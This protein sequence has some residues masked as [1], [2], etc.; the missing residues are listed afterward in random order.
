MGNPTDTGAVHHRSPQRARSW[1]PA[2][3]PPLLVPPAKP[4]FRYLS[5]VT[6]VQTVDTPHNAVLPTLLSRARPRSQLT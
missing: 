1:T 2:V 6:P 4:A 3:I 5:A